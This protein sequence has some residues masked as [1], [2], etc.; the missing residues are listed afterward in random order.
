MDKLTE[1]DISNYKINK[2]KN[3]LSKGLT[4]AKSPKDLL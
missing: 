3:H 2:K 1:W 4:T